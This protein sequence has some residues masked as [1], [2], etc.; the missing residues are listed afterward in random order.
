MEL[1]KV[2]HASILLLILPVAVLAQQPSSVTADAL[3][4]ALGETQKIV[5]KTIEQTGVPGIAIAV[6]HKDDVVFQQGF[7]VRE[8]GKPE[9]IDADTVC[10]L[11]SVSKSITS[12]VLAALVGEG[13]IGWDDRVI[14]HDPG[15]CL[16]DAAS[17]RELRLRDLLCHR[18]S[19]PDHGGDL[20]ED[21]GYDRGEI[22]H[23]LR[24]LRPDSSF[25]AHY[26]YTN[27]GY[28][29]AAVAAA[30]AAGKRWEDLAAE[31]LY[32]PLGMNTTSS[33]YEDFAKAANRARLHVRIDDKWVAKYER[34]PDAQTPAGGVSSTLRDLTCWMRLLLADGKFDDRQ[35]IPAAPL[36]ETHSPQIVTGFDSQA[37]RLV[38]YGLGWIVS[39]ERGGKVFWKHS[40]GFDLG[41]RTEVAFL[42][43]EQIGIAV[44]SNAGPTGV[45]EGIT[46]SFFDLL[47]DGKLSRDWVEFANRMFAEEVRRER[48]KETDYSH[49]PAQ[50][51]Q[52]L[53]LATYTGTFDNSFFGP[54]EITDEQGNLLLTLGPKKMP[55]PLR[56]WDRDV[57]IY[58]PTGEMAGGVSGLLFTIGPDQKSTRV[59]IENLNVHGQ[60]TFERASPG[61]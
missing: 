53:G 7:G 24:Y 43:A 58:Q 42:P 54:I 59:L 11:A 3:K 17:T 10:Q 55:F 9:L 40:G 16:Y 18:S 8:I 15:F 46:E 38:S 14:D 51:T 19:L 27:Y 6:V 1:V 13:I 49:P 29:E 36:N 2:F 47:L 33:R 52:H 21:M 57:F 39:V 23:R 4:V 45:P 5:T 48:G 32:R 41:M 35:V 20:L 34:Q 22:L 61:K 44:L 37:G 56:H 60:G 30:L 26:A 12:T 28:T 31:K 25:R 50:T